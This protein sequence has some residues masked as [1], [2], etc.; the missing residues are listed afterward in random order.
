MRLPLRPEKA[1]FLAAVRTR[2]PTLADA[3]VGH[4]TTSL[5]HLAHIAIQLGGRQLRW[6]PAAEKFPDDEAANKLLNRPS[7]RG[8]WKLE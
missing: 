3:E 4:R 1:D 7:M 8:P 5:C 2:G 6:D